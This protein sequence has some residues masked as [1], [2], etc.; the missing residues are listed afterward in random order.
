MKRQEN[1]RELLYWADQ[2]N[3]KN[4]D[5]IACENFW[6]SRAASF[7]KGSKKSNE[8][9]QLVE[10]FKDRGILT[11]EKT[12]LDIGAGTGVY[13]IPMGKVSKSVTSIDIAQN[14]LDIIG[15]KAKEEKLTNMEIAKLNWM[16]IDLK[17][18]GWEDKFDLV[19]ASMSPAIHDYK[20]LVKMTK[21][22]KGY[23]YLSAWV[24]RDFKIE[25]ALFNL[26]NKSEG[27]KG[28][29]EDKIYFAFNVLWN[30]GYYPEVEFKERKRR[31]TFS[32]EEAY[33]SY[34]K[35]LMIK[36]KLDEKD[37]ENIMNYLEKNSENGVV[38]EELDSVVGS[39]LWKVK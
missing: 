20:T 37:K 14:M 5:F 32:I 8:A 13:G 4:M 12:V 15:E 36:N 35:K 22:S 28:V 18:Y 33:E 6:D 11:S 27:K 29:N 39:L 9:N 3:E 10:K 19:F 1:K 30:L 25:D 16:D 21:A 26:V 38:V 31:T 24:K 23:C 17:S 34:I 7:D 2:Y